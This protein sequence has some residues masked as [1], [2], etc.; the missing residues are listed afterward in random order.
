MHTNRMTSPLWRGT[1]VA[2]WPVARS[3][4]GIPYR[5]PGDRLYVLLLSNPGGGCCTAWTIYRG[6]QRDEICERDRGLSGQ[7]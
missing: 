7:P 2:D 6:D 3:A 5:D 1:F 4:F